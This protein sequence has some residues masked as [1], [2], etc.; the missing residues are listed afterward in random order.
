[1]SKIISIKTCPTC[2]A[3]K[4]LDDFFRNRAQASGRHAHC[5]KCMI[6]YR[7]AYRKTEKGRE[8]RRKHNIK[9]ETSKKG[10][11]TSAH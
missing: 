7:R 3:E 2:K 6:A 1:M 8:L 4:S 5:K 9:Y 11:E 10:R